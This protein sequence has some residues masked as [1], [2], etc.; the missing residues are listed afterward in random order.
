ML[1]QKL[2]KCTEI[3]A[4]HRV[5]IE[6]PIKP[7]DNIERIALDGSDILRWGLNESFPLPEDSGLLVRTR[8]G[9]HSA[10]IHCKEVGDGLVSDPT[11]GRRATD[12]Q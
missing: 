6:L 3:I 10:W 5:V 2:D 8:Q 12:R 1:K 11:H 9:G 7:G 4:D